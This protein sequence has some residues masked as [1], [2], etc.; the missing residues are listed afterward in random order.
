MNERALAPVTNGNGPQRIA[1]SA[2]VTVVVL[3]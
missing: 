1:A 2:V 3:H